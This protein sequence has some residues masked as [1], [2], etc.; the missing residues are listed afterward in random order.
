MSAAEAELSGLILYQAELLL[1]G[2]SEE[3]S[4]VGALPNNSTEFGS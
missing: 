2:V 1:G 3:V 4:A